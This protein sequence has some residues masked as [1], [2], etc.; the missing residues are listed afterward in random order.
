MR[1]PRGLKFVKM[2]RALVTRMAALVT[3]TAALQTVEL[4]IVSRV[5]SEKVPS[6]QLVSRWHP[7]G[8]GSIEVEYLSAVAVFDILGDED[9]LELP[10]V[11]P[12]PI[13]LLP[14]PPPP[15]PHPQLKMSRPRVCWVG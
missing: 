2:L 14:P 8:T 4:V 10:E 7:S 5:V 9:A 1:T 12:A 13:S 3:Q 11:T 6:H 15:H